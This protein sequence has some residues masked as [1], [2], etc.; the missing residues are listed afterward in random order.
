MHCLGQR[1]IES[2]CQYATHAMQ[3]HG[4]P[5]GHQKRP[6]DIVEPPVAMQPNIQC[7]DVGIF[8]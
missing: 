8:C 4:E 7:R 2:G 5:T 1:T 3:V 6:P